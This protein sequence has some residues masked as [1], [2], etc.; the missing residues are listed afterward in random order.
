LLRS[1]APERTTAG[2]TLIEVLVALAIVAV[3]LSSIGAVIATTV[4]GTRSIEHRMTRLETA[5][6]IAIALPHRDKLMPGNSSGERAGYRW[7]LD[8]SP[9]ITTNVGPRQQSTPWVPQTV[10][11]TV[12]PP[13]GPSLQISTVRLRRRAG[14]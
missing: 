5:R 4:R 14:G 1:T 2:F 8:V 6:A 11:V 10:V 13:A 3:S 9:F 12:Q 7:R